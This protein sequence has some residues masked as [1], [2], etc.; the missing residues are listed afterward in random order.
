MNML[1]EWDEIRSASESEFYLLFG[2]E[3]GIERAE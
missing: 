3:K 2:G 1:I